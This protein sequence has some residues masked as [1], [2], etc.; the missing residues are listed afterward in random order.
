MDSR[1]FRNKDDRPYVHMGSWEA[2]IVSLEEN[3]FNHIDFWKIQPQGNFFHRRAFE[4][5]I[6]KSKTRPEPL[7]SF[8][9]GIPI[10][11]VTESV[12]LGI[13]IARNL[14]CIIDHT[15]LT[16]AFRWSG[17]LGRTINSWASPERDISPRISKQDVITTYV[18]VPINVALDQIYKFVNTAL[19]PLYDNFGNLKISSGV[20][21]EIAASVLKK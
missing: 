17:L 3:S 2:F 8:D 10:W 13:A 20:I 12:A 15:S 19:I 18:T 16:F 11:R 6:S 1:D 7:T 4:D 14:N 9:F 5:D 21:Q